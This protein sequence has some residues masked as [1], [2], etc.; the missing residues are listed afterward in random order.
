MRSRLGASTV[1]IPI[2]SLKTAGGVISMGDVPT[3]GA[4]TLAI[5]LAGLNLAAQT[6]TAQAGA[7]AGV[8]QTVLFPGMTAEQISFPA[9]QA[10][11]LPSY[12]V[13]FL[14]K[15]LGLVAPN[16]LSGLPERL[17]WLDTAARG[18]VGDTTPYAN[19]ITFRQQAVAL[20]KA[21]VGNAQG[22]PN[23]ELVTQGRQGPGYSACGDL[24]NFVPFRMGC[25]DASIINRD[26]PGAG[27]TYTS[28]YNISKPY[29]ACKKKG[30]V[31]T[32]AEGEPQPGD[33][34]LI[35]QYPQEKEHALVLLDISGNQWTS[36]DFGQALPEYG[37]KPSSGI[38]TRTLS[39]DSLGG[40]RVVGWIDLE[41]MGYIASPDLTGVPQPWPGT[42]NPVPPP[43]WGSMDDAPALCVA[44]GWTWDGTKCVPQPNAS[45]SGGSTGSGGGSDSTGILVVGA[46]ALL[47]LA[48]AFSGSGRKANPRRIE[49]EMRRRVSLY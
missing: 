41:G 30:I 28:S 43:G 18:R 27:L 45:P 16:L 8:L 20:V 15:L 40:R 31:H 49:D 12:G 33:L 47:G 38:R 13:S 14:K 29:W 23:F 37:Y 3:T 10:V 36:G 1:V 42:T 44:K 21:Y 5:D 11:V 2:A 24:W 25:R 4:P 39:G 34:V 6:F 32:L 35:G 7:M 22:Y 48:L 17:R 46:L 26:E 19:L 9:G